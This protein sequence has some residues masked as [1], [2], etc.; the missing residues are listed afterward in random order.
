MASFEWPPLAGSG[1]GTVT[2]VSVATANG[3]AGTVATSTTTPA[4]TL[5]TTVTGI[6][7]GNGTFI[8]AATTGNLTEVTS[9]ILTITGGTNAVLGTGVSL[10]VNQA[11]TS[12]SGY[13]SSTDWNSFQGKQAS[14]NYITA[15]TGDITASGPGSS[16]STLAT[17]NT[18]VGSFAISTVTVNGKGLVTAASAAATTGSG[19]V[20]LASSP[21]LV[22]PALG[23]PSALVG[24]NIT[25]TAAGLTAGTVTTNANLTGPITSSGN[26]TSIASQTG[27]GTTFV[28]NTSPTLVTPALGTPSALVL[29]TGVTGTLPVGS[30]PGI[31]YQGSMANAASWTATSTG[32]SFVD[33]TNSGGNTLTAVYSNGITVT[34]AASN[35][36][37]ISFT[38]PAVTSAYVITA[39]FQASETVA[40]NGSGYRFTDGTTAFAWG[41]NAEQSGSP[42]DVLFQM[43]LHGIYVPGTTSAVTVKIQQ[44]TGSGTDS[45]TIS[46][47]IGTLVPSIVW[48][49]QQ[50]R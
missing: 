7:Q 13:L 4:I 1:S 48:T 50:I 22:T 39:T 33:G 35:I 44:T 17:V 14:G 11:S 5:S 43:V 8:S 16:A 34:A 21:T 26:A 42:V 24:T 41:A 23:T 20:V 40:G 12:V 37:G 10:Q 19:S 45:N 31:Y 36:A 49:V 38:P 32:T 47:A 28:M 6:L 9:S 29:S 30:L 46:G 25:G 27:T 15:L 2:S 3:F 18:N